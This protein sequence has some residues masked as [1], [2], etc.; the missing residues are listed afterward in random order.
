MAK[1]PANKRRA[2]ETHTHLAI[3]VQNFGASSSAS[4][5]HAA[6]GSNS[7]WYAD[8]E[9]PVYVLRNQ[10]TVSGK[11][12]DPDERSG[13]WYDITLSGGSPTTSFDLDAKLK[14]LAERDEYGAPRYRKYRGRDVAIYKPPP[15]L[16]LLEKVRGETAWTAWL[17]VK[18]ALIEQ[19]LALL[20]STSD[21][22]VAVHECKAKRHR[23]IRS[24]ELSTID[25]ADS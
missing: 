15:G 4:I 6:Y 22:Y 11:A 16:G 9:E 12:I 8:G 18:P 5:N 2:E 19:W 21:L 14:D 17:F 20:T 7:S 1:K 3:S 24:I 23:W 13:D 25:P 10:L